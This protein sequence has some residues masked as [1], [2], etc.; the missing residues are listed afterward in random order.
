MA[1]LVR[2]VSE[3]ILTNI[4]FSWYLELS[5]CHL[6]FLKMDMILTF[7]IH[8][9]LYKYVFSLKILVESRDKYKI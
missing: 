7:C 8:L 5:V 2:V 3:T 9:V 4:L 6:F 1:V